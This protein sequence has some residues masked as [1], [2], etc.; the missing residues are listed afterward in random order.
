MNNKFD[1]N[2]IAEAAPFEFVQY[3][4]PR[5]SWSFDELKVLGFVSWVIQPLLWGVTTPGEGRPE[6]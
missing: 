4:P 3:Y 6:L 2:Y 1:V 5:D